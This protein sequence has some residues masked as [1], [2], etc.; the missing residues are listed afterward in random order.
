M[1]DSN[2]DRCELFNFEATNTSII[3]FNNNDQDE[4]FKY[5]DTRNKKRLN[6]LSKKAKKTQ[7]LTDRLM[8]IAERC[9]KV[10]KDVQTA[11]SLRE[12]HMNTW[13]MEDS[14]FR[15]MLKDNSIQSDED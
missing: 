4:L 13:E 11:G 3:A 6:K 8:D 1:D 12:K 7:D 2:L 10:M 5:Y 14:N 9:E 15:Q